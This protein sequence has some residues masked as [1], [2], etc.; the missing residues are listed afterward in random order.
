MAAGLGTALRTPAAEP[1]PENELKAA[2]VYNFI[3]FTEWPPQ[4]L[5]GG[6]PIRLCAGAASP[7]LAALGALGDKQVNGHRIV[8]QQGVSGRACHVLVLDQHDR[9]RWSQTRRE[10]AGAAVLTVADEA[11]AGADGAVIALATDERRIAFDVDLAAMRSAHLNL[12]S[13]LL[14]L[15]R[16]AQ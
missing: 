6:A 11:G 13:K 7:L 16:S 4:A 3:F 5:A 12:S 10:L 14:R 8:L 15:A 9:E 2:F 1:V